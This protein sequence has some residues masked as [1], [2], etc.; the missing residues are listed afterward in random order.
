MK[1]VFV[2]GNTPQLSLSELKSASPQTTLLS[3]SLLEYTG[4]LVEMTAE[5]AMLIAE[6]LGGTVKLIQLD[7][8]LEEIT[9]VTLADY[10]L[11][12]DTN[13]KISFGLSSLND[14]D[15]KV[16]QL[17]RDIK[18]ELQDRDI[19]ARFVMPQ[20]GSQ[21]S[22]VV[23]SKQKVVEL[24]VY[25][26]QNFYLVGK[27]VWVQ[28][29]QEWNRRDYGRPQASGHIGMLPLKVARMMVNLAQV[30]KGGTILD[31][32]CGVGTVLAEAMV[33]GYR[34]FG[35][36]LDAGQVEK[37]RKNL[38]WLGAEYNLK[39][40]L[41]VGDARNVS[42]ILNEKVAAVVTEPDLGPNDLRPQ[43]APDVQNRLISL[44]T[45][46]LADWKRILEPL[47]TVVIALP[48]LVNDGSIV[49][50]VIDKAEAMG[51]SLH[52]HPVDYFRP[53]AKVR[54]SIA[55]FKLKDKN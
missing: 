54:R 53:G 26:W 39:F 6:K 38:E 45:G 35:S 41:Q 36:D 23:I 24:A 44:Y 52:V 55:I 14:P 30:K 25:K 16:N 2:F 28:D 47:G 8:Q 34:V 32:Y 50:A 48:K 22:S 40:K 15:L 3:V 17:S 11:S 19:K 9:P 13:Q 18:R 29:F 10:L 51:Y 21:L 46:S 20:E 31:P 12:T 5:Q 42:N 4:A 7:R 33:L 49:Q 43:Y 37:T 1:F 27:T